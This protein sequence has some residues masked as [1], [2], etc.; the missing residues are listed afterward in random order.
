M[1]RDRRA[2]PFLFITGYGDVE[3]A[4]QL[5]RDGARDYL[6]KPFAMS[7]FLVR[8]GQV[9][10]SSAD[11]DGDPVLGVSAAMRDLERFLRRAARVTLQRAAD[12]RDRRWQGG[13]RP[14]PAP[15][16]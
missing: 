1:T 2:P 14:V 8:V 16:A 11:A 3:Q 15:H 6:T 13:M 4:V 7:G 10:G 12:R 9:L 5:M